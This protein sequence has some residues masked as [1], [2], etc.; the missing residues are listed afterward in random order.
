[1]IFEFENFKDKKLVIVTHQS[2]ENIKAAINKNIK[3][4]LEDI[5]GE[6]FKYSI[7][8]VDKMKKFANSLSE[9]KEIIEKLASNQVQIEKCFDRLAEIQNKP[10]MFFKL[11]QVNTKY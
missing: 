9:L 3:H 8:T 7:K 4:I 1:M 5:I 10:E 6:N 11:K 2:Y